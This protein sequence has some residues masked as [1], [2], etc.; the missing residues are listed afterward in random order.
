MPDHLESSSAGRQRDFLPGLRLPRQRSRPAITH[1]DLALAELCAKPFSSPGW[2][3]EVKYDGYRCLGR[4]SGGQAQLL[5]RDGRDLSR[6]FPELVE[7]L[8]QLPE[9]TAIDGE[10]V[11]L[12]ELGCPRFD[13]LL[14]RSAV[15][16][17]DIAAAA[18]RNRPATLFSWDILMLAHEDLRRFPLLARK[19]TLE[20]TLPGL[21]HIHAAS[22]VQQHGER[23][24]AE[25][26][27]MELEGIMAKRIDSRY[28]AGRTTDWLE[29]NAPRP[30]RPGRNHGG[31]HA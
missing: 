13:W 23:L 7:D 20:A 17:S 11:L 8:A 14:E 24:Y 18:A 1:K 4:H 28:S 2:V 15:F 12:D 30:A 22:H 25:T 29:I 27:S 21:K 16:R 3:F 9:G 10:L 26:V 19:V 5:T 6:A 31:P